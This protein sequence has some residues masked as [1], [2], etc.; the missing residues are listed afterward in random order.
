MKSTN[1]DIV[2]NAKLANGQVLP[3]G[4]YRLEFPLNTQSPKLKFYQD[5]KL[6]ATAPAH[7]KTEPSKADA[8][9]I[10]Y[11]HTGDAQY[12]TE[13]RPEGMNEALVLTKSG[14]MKSGS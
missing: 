14:K 13:V 10:A 3:E 11:R 12:I 5:G 6:V 2:Y 1:V 9:E 7:I 4:K 8:T